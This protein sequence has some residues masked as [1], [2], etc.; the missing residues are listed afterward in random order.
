MRL[1]LYLSRCGICSRRKAHSLVKRGCVKVNTEVIREPSYRV[2]KTDR[3]YFFG[4]LIRPLEFLYVMV[5]KPPGFTTTLKD[6]FAKR[7]ITDLIPKNFPRL[8][9]AGRLDKNSRGLVIF[10]NDGEFIHK[11]T[12][13]RFTIEKE[14]EVKIRPRLRR[15]HIRYIVDGIKEG[16]DILRAKRVKVLKDYKDKSLLSMV[17]IQ[18]K[19][20]QIRRML[21]FLGYAVL[22]LKRTRIGN[23]R[24]GRLKEGEYRLISQESIREIFSILKMRCLKEK[25]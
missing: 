17:L 21:D 20:R 14:Y 22:D 13:S 12:H 11:I 5:N 15:E 7:K 19:K 3:V 16:K 4:R 2:E 18:G 23:L 10:S 6:R 1:S 8:V 24:L 9:P 25:A